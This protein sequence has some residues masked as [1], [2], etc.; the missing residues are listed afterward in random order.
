[1]YLDKQRAINHK[2][3]IPEKN[4][5]IVAL[6]GGAVGT[7]LGMNRFR[8]KTKH[9]SFKLGFPFLAFVEVAL[10]IYLVVSDQ[11]NF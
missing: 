7:T 10:I 9:I 5:W 1:M 11:S 8:H 3:R 4:L 6:I 2:Y